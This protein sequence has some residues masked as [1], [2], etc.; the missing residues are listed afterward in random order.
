MELAQK[1]DPK[2]SAVIVVDVQNDFCHPDGIGAK[3]GGHSHIA[4]HQE[5]A[6]NLV[7]FIAQAR[8]AQVPIIFIRTIHNKWTESEA[9]IE[10][11]RLSGREYQPKCWGDGWG[12]EFYGDVR[13]QAEDCIVVKHRHSAFVATDL[14]LI[15]RCQRIKTIV[16]TGLN[17]N[18]C[19]Q[20]TGRDGFMLD[21]HV[22]YVSDC[23]ATSGGWEKHEE[24]LK[25]FCSYAEVRTSNE[26][27]TVWQKTL[28]LPA[29]S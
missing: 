27:A 11:H 4:M 9:L 14:D 17:T 19:V 21:Y 25:S 12:S 3:V 29:A 1:I 13:P 10:S 24:A 7:R 6:P 20:A 15:L 5:M 8:Q 2:H 26:L 18:I 23:C 22:V 16:L 28:S